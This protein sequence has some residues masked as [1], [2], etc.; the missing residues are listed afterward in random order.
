MAGGRLDCMADVG[1][2]D[3]DRP[4]GGELFIYSS[5]AITHDNSNIYC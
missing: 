2:L 3:G 1:R 5:S 4:G